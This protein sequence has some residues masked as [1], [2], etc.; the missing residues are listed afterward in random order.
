MSPRV[1]EG[2]GGLM[3]RDTGPMEQTI[4]QGDAAE[5]AASRRLRVMTSAKGPSAFDLEGSGVYV[6]GRGGD[7]R[8]G[9]LP[10]AV[11]DGAMD[12]DG[13]VTV[14]GGT[15]IDTSTTSVFPEET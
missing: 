14:S 15:P 9:D 3:R 13:A 1:R 8:V 5:R 2:V 7:W 4:L 10:C 11:D 12:A 6:L